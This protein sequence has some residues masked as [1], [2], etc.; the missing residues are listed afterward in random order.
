MST[1]QHV[2]RHAAESTQEQYPWRAVIR[3]VFEAAVSFAATWPLVVVALGLDDGWQWVTASL[4]VTGGITK[5][6][7]L[8]QVNAWL[9]RFIPWLA[10]QPPADDVVDAK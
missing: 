4:V 10:A 3:T 9:E 6:M 5:L 7:A 2:A 8:P 1:P